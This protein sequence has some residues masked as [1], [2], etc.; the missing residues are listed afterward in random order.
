MRNLLRASSGSS[1]GGGESRGGR[2]DVFATDHDHGSVSLSNAKQPMN[3]NQAPSP[4]R[5][6]KFLRASSSGKRDTQALE[7]SRQHARMLSLAASSED[8]PVVPS[9]SNN[10]TT[11]KSAPTSHKNNHVSPARPPRPSGGAGGLEAHMR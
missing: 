8:D 5:N 9:T 11:S 2:G 10:N 7:K 3:A 6:F 1:V 4:R